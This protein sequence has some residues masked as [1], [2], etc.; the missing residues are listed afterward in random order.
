VA[1]STSS[2]VCG[3]HPG[4]YFVTLILAYTHSDASNPRATSQG[5][6]VLHSC[7]C[8]QLAFG[9]TVLLCCMFLQGKFSLVVCFIPPFREVHISTCFMA[10]CRCGP[11]KVMLPLLVKLQE[12]QSDIKVY[13]LNCNK[14]NK[15]LGVKL[16]VKVAPTFQLYK[17][18]N[19]VGVCCL[20]YAS[21]SLCLMCYLGK[22]AC[23]L[24]DTHVHHCIAVATM[25]HIGGC[26]IGMQSRQNCANLKFG[27]PHNWSCAG[28]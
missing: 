8:M 14:K 3:A 13:K 5:I 20:A 12:E 15:E 2:V 28:G 1:A 10:G 19:K 16:N 23:V 17:N 25:F 7:P 26:C 9:R 6:H 4:W 21:C 24:L 11:C 27:R 18:K 22:Q